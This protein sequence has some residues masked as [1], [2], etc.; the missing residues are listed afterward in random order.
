MPSNIVRIGVTVVSELNDNAIEDATVDILFYDTTLCPYMHS[1]LTGS[2]QYSHD[3]SLGADI[4]S[5]YL[6]VE[7]SAPNYMTKKF[8]LST[9]S[10]WQNEGAYKQY[11]EQ[12]DYW[13]YSVVILV[14]LKPSANLE[15]VD[16]NEA[17]LEDL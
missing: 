7:I 5:P 10:D 11:F 14:K 2:T 6:I 8:T 17:P 4:P 13:L 12:E 9:S 1:G 16:V 3:F 15:P